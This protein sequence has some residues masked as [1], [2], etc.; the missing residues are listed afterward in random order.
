MNR[1]NSFSALRVMALLMLFAA[2][3]LTLAQLIT[4]SRLRALYPTGMVVAGIPIGGLDRN[5]AAQRLVEAYSLPVELTYG[6]ARIQ[7]TPQEVDFQVDVDSMLA[8]ADLESSQTTFWADF[9]DYLWGR[10]QFPVEIPL[11][12]NVSEAR[13][14]DRLAEIAARYDTPPQ[15]ALPLPG[16]VN[17]EPGRSGEQ[18]DIEGALL[19][20]ENALASLTNRQ[21][22]LPIQR[23]APGRPAFGNI[24]ILL[25][26]IIKVDGFQ[27]LVG[28]YMQ[29]LQTGQEVHFAEMAGAPV[30]VEPTEVAYSASSI[31]KIPIM[32][33][34]FRRMNGDPDPETLKLLTDMIDRSGNEASDWLMN[35]VIDS[36]K[37]PLLISEDLKTIGL[38]NTFLAGYFGAGSPLLATFQTP[39]N[40]RTDISTDP[41]IYNQTTPEEIG[42]LLAD[43]YTCAQTGGGTLPA[44]FPGEI[45][46]PE[47]QTMIDFLLANKLPVL[48]TG[49]LPEGTPIAH[50]HGWVSGSGVFNMIGDAG[51]VYTPGGNYVMVVFMHDPNEMIWEP[52]SQLVSQLSRAVYNY[53]NLPSEE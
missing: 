48:L 7:I 47:C 19:L 53:Y 2:M 28:I 18:L 5:G 22:A 3:G 25:K 21:V 38:E 27:G 10:T 14:R 13:L 9:W 52:A 1:R 16:S 15:T 46:Q 41:D 42:L 33:G 23:R 49:G 50:K 4:F 40:Q 35:R 26:Q 12:T 6:D 24:E 44:A 17:F 39:A 43:L 36:S 45:T 32:L 11:R 31:M 51:I 29:D 8:A 34:A 20:I 30:A 37:A